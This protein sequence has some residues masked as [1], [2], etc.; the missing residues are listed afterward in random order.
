MYRSRL[1]DLQVRPAVE[2]P[3]M[4]I[5]HASEELRAHGHM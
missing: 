4:E 2:Y 5:D 3:T 1:L